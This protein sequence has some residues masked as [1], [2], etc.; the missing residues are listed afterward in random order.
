MGSGEDTREKALKC[1]LLMFGQR[2]ILLSNP[3]ITFADGFH[4]YCQSAGK[5]TS[6]DLC[7]ATD[8]KSM[9]ASAAFNERSKASGHC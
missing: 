4:C 3:M 2:M 9:P 8:G 5:N 6:D 7:S 1:R